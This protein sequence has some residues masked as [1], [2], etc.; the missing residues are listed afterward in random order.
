L[1]KLDGLFINKPLLEFWRYG[2]GK[3]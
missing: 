1:L 2:Y 3:L